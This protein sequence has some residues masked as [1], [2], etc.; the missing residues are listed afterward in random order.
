MIISITK[1]KSIINCIPNNYKKKLIPLFSY[2]LI[3]VLLDLVSIA[4]LLP[5]LMLIFNPK[6]SIKNKFL[7]FILDPTSIYY[8]VFILILFFIIKN[9]ISIRIIKYQSKLVYAISS[10]ISKNYTTEFIKKGYLNYQKKIKGT[11]IKNTI[12]IPNAFVNYVLISMV[13]L[14]SEIFIIVIISI[15]AL[16]YFTDFSI[17]IFV[18]I[19]LMLILIYT[20]RKKKLNQINK[21]L[22]TAYNTNI[23]YLLDIIDGY[24]NIKSSSKES[25]FLNRFN[26]SNKKLNSIYGYM[27]A[28]RVSNNKFIEIIIVIV[29][30]FLVIYLLNYS[31]NQYANNL[32]LVSF[33]ASISLKLI[34]SLNKI[35]IS[36]SNLKA[37]DYTINTILKNKKVIDKNEKSSEMEFKNSLNLKNISFNYNESYQLFKN[38]NLKINK[39]T[40]IGISGRTG[41]GKT[42]LI[43]IILN[44]LK[45]VSGA[46]YFDDETN[47]NNSNWIKKFG[48]VS[49]QTH[50]YSGTLLNNIAV[51]ELPH[52]INF[53]K[54]NDLIK[55]FKFKEDINNFS[56]G[57][58]TNTGNSGQLLSGGQKQ[59]IALI[60][61][62]YFNPKILILDEATNQLDIENER[63]ILNYIKKLVKENQLTV[64]IISHNN[65]VLEYCD[66]IYKL[67]NQ[68]LYEETNI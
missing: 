44:L 14:F 40:I 45:P 25:Y 53:N 10:E 42:T 35:F 65:K 17:Y 33:L 20:Y 55:T 49:Q 67:K 60:R 7:N 29:I 66:K 11:I 31:N 1:I 57:L 38:I 32:V 26:N 16:I 21:N 8:S 37:Y 63:L 9:I 23:N 4:I 18:L 68:M 52:E 19:F 50:I 27:T 41:S 43:H 64:I 28:M 54:I 12:N 24:L 51:G 30:S 48:Y 22:S 62:L 34:P 47:L 6:L 39:G 59:K 36:F 58:N 56:E 46:I 2:N 3:N 5:F 13:T 15:I 61:T